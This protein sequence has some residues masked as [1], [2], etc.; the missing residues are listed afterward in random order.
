[1]LYHRVGDPQ[2]PT[3]GRLV[4]ALGSRPFEAQVRHFLAHYRLVPAGELVEAARARRR[5]QRVPLAITFDDD[6]RCHL[7]VAAPIL[8]RLGAPATFF[9]GGASADAPHPYWWQLLQRA[10]DL[11][12]SPDDELLRP[13]R[14]RAGAPAPA[15]PR[16]LAAGV[17]LLPAPERE[18]L[19]AAL[20]D[21]VGGESPEPGLRDADLRRLVGMG[22][23]LGFHTLRHPHLTLLDADG[24]TRALE[25]GRGRIEAITGAP[26]RIIAYPFGDVDE[27]VAR[28]AEAAGY[29]Y[30]FT[31]ERARLDSRTDPLLIGRFQP[32]YLSAGHTAMELARAVVRPA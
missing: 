7:D 4:P 32:S 15:L 9:V 16:Q 17:R 2:E 10:L 19:T 8:E 31:T 11:G 29:T 3:G 13:A 22:F 23:E 25:D 28:A 12:L 26:V 20:L 14:E 5:G 6:L 30:G 18:D 27:R 24:L 1:M 21:R